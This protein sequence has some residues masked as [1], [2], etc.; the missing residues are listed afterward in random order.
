[1][2][3]LLSRP[4][5]FLGFDS[6]LEFLTTLIALAIGYWSHRVYKMNRQPKHFYLGFSFFAIAGSYL[7]KALSNMVV[8]AEANRT[9]VLWIKLQN[10]AML[11]NIGMIFHVALIFV[12]Y[13]TLVALSLKIKDM[14]VISL[15]LVTVV[16]ATILSSSSFL[17]FHVLSTI[18]LLYVIP[19]FW[20]HY[21]ESRDAHS[22]V[23]LISFLLIT[24]SHICFILLLTG[25]PLFYVYGEFAQVAGYIG[26]LA[27]LVWCLRYG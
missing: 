22:R 11:H 8:L 19:Y 14:R 26:L 24:L 1:M 21:Q 6:L 20:R 9:E 4:D 13:I 18:L 5:W 10:M 16:L 15:L 25:T 17:Y 27:N 12:A 23:V 7:A 2:V 3:F